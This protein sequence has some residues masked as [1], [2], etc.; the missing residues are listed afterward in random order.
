MSIILFEGMDGTGKST[1]VKA[2]AEALD[3]AGKTA[4]IQAFPSKDGP[5]GQFIREAIFTGE[6][7]VDERAMLPL[8]VADA[9]DFDKKIGQWNQD[10]DFVLLD[11]HSIISAWAY[12]LGTHTPSAVAAIASPTLFEN[13]PSSIFILD[14]PEEVVTA[15]LAARGEKA[16]PLYEK[17]IE[18]TRMLR[19]RYMAVQSIFASNAP[20][21]MLDAT[22][23]TDLLAEI[24]VE[25]L[26]KQACHSA[27]AGLA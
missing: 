26:L 25:S 27:V 7:E 6:V 9:L 3:V 11:R 23:P 14:A 18:Y 15:R 1:L 19:S 4:R 2:V 17:G 10:F 13:L 16:N 24:I 8:M 5:I 22:K 12:Q 20:M 21:M